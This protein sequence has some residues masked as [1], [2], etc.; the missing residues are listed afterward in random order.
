[1][2][3]IR[4]I[5]KG[6]FPGRND[7]PEGS[8]FA[9]VRTA[10]SALEA[11]ARDLDPLLL[12]GRDAAE[13]LEV[14]ARGKRV[15]AAMET[16][17]ARRVDGRRSGVTRATTRRQQTTARPVGNAR[18][19]VRLIPGRHLTDRSRRDRRDRQ[20][21]VPRSGGGTLSPSA[22]LPRLPAGQEEPIRTW[23]EHEHD[24]TPGPGVRGSV[25]TPS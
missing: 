18:P 19:S 25:R 10:V 1:M 7:R 21:G 15:C 9:E 5:Q 11:V 13:L 8:V 23:N 22:R 14:L 17:L 2:A 20:G 12:D 16:L 4:S 3:N 6:R 24:R